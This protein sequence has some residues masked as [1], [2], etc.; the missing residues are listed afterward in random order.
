[1][2]TQAKM[3]TMQ[4]QQASG[5][6][7]TDY[8]GLAGSARTLISLEVS[9][10]RSKGYSDS[11][12]EA[13][14]RV[15]T[16]HQKLGIATDLLTQF[17]SQ[18]TAMRSTDRTAATSA[19]LADS[20][21]AAMEQFA[22]ILNATYA[23]RYLFAGS[24]TTTPPVDIGTYRTATATDDSYYSGDDYLAKVQV[25]ADHIVSYGVTADETG[26]QQALGAMKMLASTT[27][28]MDDAV[29]EQAFTLASEALDAV[30]VLQSR[31]GVASDTLQTAT[32]TQEDYQFFVKANISNIKDVDATELAVQLAA[33]GTQLEASYAALAKI[34]SLN[35]QDY[36]R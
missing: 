30:T 1:M 35:L 12:T 5:L 22:N 25:S 34:Q 15:E 28:M 23:G 21:S 13:N 27:G 31:L 14:F 3:A 24:V 4:L 20:A 17:R 7:S 9:M 16:M 33:Y 19:V 29:L 6:T 2:Q 10:E 32:Q 11:A 26:F 36:L 8:G 18:I